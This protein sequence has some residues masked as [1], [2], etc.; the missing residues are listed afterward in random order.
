MSAALDDGAEAR[1]RQRPRK[2]AA[3]RRA[4]AARA[5]G[6]AICRLLKCLGSVRD[7]RGGQLSVLGAALADALTA[8]G[9]VAQGGGAAHR[10]A[11]HL[12]PSAGGARCGG[13]R[14]Q[15]DVDQGG[16]AAHRSAPHLGPSAGEVRGRGGSRGPRGGRRGV[17]TQGGG[18]VRQGAPHL[19]PPPLRAEAQVFVP[20]A[21][22]MAVAAPMQPAVEPEVARATA[23]TS[24]AYLDTLTARLMGVVPGTSPA[25]ARAALQAS[26]G[27]YHPAR[28]RLLAQS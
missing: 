17:A 3:E 15:G 22:G 13:D 10:C 23:A 2:S 18:V 6:R 20:S 11:P 28:R 12:G 19:G 24:E 16:G 27:L 8:R 21:Q 26:G 14:P 7:H 9:G 4:Q 1:P 5:E 25:A